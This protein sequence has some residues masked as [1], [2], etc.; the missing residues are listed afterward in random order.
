[1]VVREYDVPEEALVREAI[2][3]RGSHYLWG[4]DVQRNQLL[5]ID[6]DTGTTVFLD[7]PF[8]G[9]TGP[10]TLVGDREGKLWVTMIDNNLLGRF[11]PV[12]MSWVLWNIE[13]DNEE[14]SGQAIV[15]DITYDSFGELAADSSDRVWAT[16]IGLN[17]FG[18][19][20]L[21]TERVE[22][23]PAPE[24]P[25]RSEFGTSLYGIVLSSD[26]RCA[27]FS[28]VNG[29]FGCFNTTTL[30]SESLIDFSEGSGPRR[31]AIDKNDVVWIPLF[32][33]GQVVK[34][35]GKARKI[36][37]RYDL[38][39]R[40]AAPYAVTWDPGREV[41][42]VANSNADAVYKFDPEQETFAVYPL[43]RKDAY[44]RQLSINHDTG[45]LTGTYGN[46]PA[47]SGPSKVFVM[48]IL[49]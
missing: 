10:H 8:D 15:H 4:A 12:D 14:F 17:K 29:Y 33:A 19:F 20:N 7:V 36:L 18:S 44:L 11:D 26:R 28:Q 31:L 23:Y 2:M 21:E 47:G 9:A 22:Y 5:Q 6:P 25:G 46:I 24:W 48:D 30:K 37:G 45:R 32:G 49:E 3:L 27:W 42:W 41:L 1:M 38:P 16:L 43:P 35:D 34:F 39:N 13:P 40:R